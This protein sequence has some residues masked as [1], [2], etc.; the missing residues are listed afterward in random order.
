[1]ENADVEAALH[2]QSCFVDLWNDCVVRIWRA[3]NN[4]QAIIIDI[5]VHD[6]VVRCVQMM[7]VVDV[8]QASL[9]F[10]RFEDF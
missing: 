7:R 6:V 1:M 10:K 3:V 2:L 5:K 4:P 8:L 9:S